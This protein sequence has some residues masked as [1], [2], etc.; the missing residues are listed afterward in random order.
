MIYV[1][2]NGTKIQEIY[3]SSFM[4]STPEGKD[5]REV[6][7]WFQGTVGQDIR[8]FSAEWELLPLELRLQQNLIPNSEKYKAIGEELILKS[9]E[10][11]VRD[12]LDKAPKGLKLDP[13]APFERPR[14][15]KMTREELVEAGE[16]TRVE[17]DKLDLKD[18]EIR[19][20]EYLSSTGWYVERFSETGKEIPENI[21]VQRAAAR[22]RISSIRELL[23]NSG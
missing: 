10:E 14:F 3:C 2:I 18:E 1:E 15:I 12:G 20:L 16:L 23:Q 13:I 9:Y 22:E 4:P 11:L 5:Y 17:A 8:E 21:K 6:P 7:S 19:L